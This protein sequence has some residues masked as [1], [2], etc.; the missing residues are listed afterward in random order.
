[1]L[2]TTRF[3]TH[4]PDTATGRAADRLGEL[5]DRHDGQ[6][7]DMVRTMAGSAALLGGYLDLSRSMK[8]SRLPRRAAELISIAVQARLGCASCLDAHIVAGLAAGLTD[9]DIALAVRGTASDPAIAALVAYAIDVHAD[10]S[11][12]DDQTLATLRSHGHR[13]R[14]LLD[15]IGLVTLNHLTGAVNLIAGLEPEE[16]MNTTTRLAAYGGLLATSFAAAAGIGLAAGPIDTGG[17][18]VHDEPHDGP[19][20]H[21]DSADDAPNDHAPLVR[22][23]TSLDAAG[24]RIEPD[25]VSVPAGEPVDYSFRLLD[26]SGASVQEFTTLHERDLHLIVASRD[27]AVYHHLHP[28][29]DGDGVWTIQLPPLGAGTYRVFADSQPANADAVTLGVDLIATDGASPSGPP[30]IATTASIDGYDVTLT[31]N[32]QVGSSML[33]FLVQ[34]DGESVTTEPYLGA[35][36]HLVVLRVGDLAYVHAHADHD[37]SD[38]DDPS[39]AFDVSFP[40]PGT[41]R[42][43]LDFAVDGTVRTADFTVQVPDHGTATPA[44][45]HA[46]PDHGGH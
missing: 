31:G 35:A 23:G 46:A 1:M 26:E 30:A 40:S 11:S 44:P 6:V 17:T 28:E 45:S 41:Y 42:L 15:V 4:T 20:G 19:K 27:L 32:P 9:D 22:A 16:T 24:I 7:S 21:D 10:P 29:H 33:S 14:D 12:V 34:R 25:L 36:G 18:T 39:I 13:D 2:A 8:R 43:F 3:P 37:T 38:T 5:W